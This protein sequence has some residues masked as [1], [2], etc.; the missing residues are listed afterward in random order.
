MKYFVM[1]GSNGQI[2]YSVHNALE[3]AEVSA[4][5]MKQL[6]PNH[7]IAVYEKIKDVEITVYLKDVK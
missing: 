4:I 3:T 7:R 5:Q 2:V 6:N 1:A